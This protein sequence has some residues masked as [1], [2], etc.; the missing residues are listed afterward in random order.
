MSRLILNTKQGPTKISVS[1][2][3]IYIY[4]CGLSDDKDGLCDGSHKKTLD[5]DEDQIYCYDENDKKTKVGKVD[6]EHE[7]CGGCK[8]E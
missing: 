1:D 7:C 2:K 8:N 6:G 4:R 3:D 5:E